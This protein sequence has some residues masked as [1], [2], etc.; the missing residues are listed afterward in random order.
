MTL[1]LDK[2]KTQKKWEKNNCLS[3]NFFENPNTD[4]IKTWYIRI[5]KNFS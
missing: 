4:D 5:F 2:T 1:S 3:K